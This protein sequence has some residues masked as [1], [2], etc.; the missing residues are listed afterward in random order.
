MMLGKRRG[1]SSGGMPGNPLKEILASTC[2][3][4][5]IC[6]TRLEGKLETANKEIELLKEQISFLKELMLAKLEDKP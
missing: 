5:A 3:S 4:A 2:R 6:E 1:R